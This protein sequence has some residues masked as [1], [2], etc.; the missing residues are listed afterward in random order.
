M[1]PIKSQHQNKVGGLEPGVNLRSRILRTPYTHASELLQLWP[2]SKSMA[3]QVTPR[4]H[5]C[6][7]DAIRSP[8]VW[9]VLYAEQVVWEENLPILN[10]RKEFSE[11]LT[12]AEFTLG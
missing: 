10:L 8:K 6:K 4:M 5:N 9:A 12:P 3:V 11:N 2:N 7:Y 1:T